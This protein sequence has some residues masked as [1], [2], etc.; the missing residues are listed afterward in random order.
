MPRLSQW[1]IRAALVNLLLGFT[2]GALLLAH[3]GV[4]YWPALWRLLPAHVEL[5]LIGWTAQ[6]A[7]GV[8]FWILPRFW[9]QPARGNEKAAWIALIL[10]NS[11]VYLVLLGSWQGFVAALFWGRMA[12]I[13]AAVAFAVAVWPR[14][15][16]RDG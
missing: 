3:K 13:G 16:G 12:E 10:L 5:V 7:L 11:G 2:F 4:P 15:A 14:I 9:R 8:A 6:L 1:F